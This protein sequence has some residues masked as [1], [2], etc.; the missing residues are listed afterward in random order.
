MNVTEKLKHFED[1]CNHDA[2]TKSD[3]MIAD[4]T[5][6][7]EKILTAHMEAATRLADA[8]IQ[9]ESEKIRRDINKQLSIRQID[10]KRTYSGKQEELKGMIFTELRDRLAQYMETSQYDE[11]LEAQIKKA[12]EF[13]KDEEVHVYIDPSDKAKQNLLAI[14]TRCDIR[15]S[16]YSFLGGTRAVIASKNVLIDNSFETKLKEAEENFQFHLGGK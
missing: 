5:Q 14:R 12:Q 11:L 8:R 16:E 9:T 15:V 10:I 3:Q 6:S 1:V 7:L 2:Q 4:Y 13:A